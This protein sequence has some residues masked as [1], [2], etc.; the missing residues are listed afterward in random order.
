MK[1]LLLMIFVPVAA[2]LF[3][4]PW[5]FGAQLEKRLPAVIAQGAR[6]A[7]RYGL[8]LQLR[9]YRRGY[10]TST[11]QM[12]L[13]Y[14]PPGE[15][16][17][18]YQGVMTLD[19]RHAP[20]LA[21]G[22]D[23]MT[24]HLFSDNDAQGVL[25]QAL[26]PDFLAAS[27]SVGL[28]GHLRIEGRLLETRTNLFPHPNRPQHLAFHGARFQ[29]DSTLT[30]YP[31]RG[32]GFVELD[33]VTFTDDEQRWHLMPLRIGFAGED[34][35][36]AQAQLPELVLQ[37]SLHALS[38]REHIRISGFRAQMQQGLSADG[39]PYPHSLQYHIADFNWAR[40]QYGETH[41]QHLRDLNLHATL[42]Q[43]DSQAPNA[44]LHVSGQALQ[45][46]LPGGW[47]DIA[48]ETF[49]S[50]LEWQPFRIEDASALLDA[51]RHP[52]PAAQYVP[53]PEA[54]RHVQLPPGAG[55][56]LHYLAGHMARDTVR[57]RWHMRLSRRDEV[58]LSAEGHLH[59]HI[60]GENSTDVLQTLADAWGHNARLPALL[61]GSRLHIFAN[62]PFV[63]KSGLGIAL[64]FSG[65]KAY[66]D[67]EGQF[68]LDALVDTGGI[69]VN[70]DLLPLAP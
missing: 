37:H 8:A 15:Q 40:E 4:L 63:Q 46:D 35:Y 9:N 3:G 1:K 32:K 43:S 14:Q 42:R 49:E 41:T 65:H 19:I 61:Q 22:F 53:L 70:G 51:L 6:E 52:L 69:T 20:L 24:A 33:G 10:F 68:K 11:A 56:V 39:K 36:E 25:A 23:F 50:T 18:L 57:A 21:S 58:L 17:P 38:A 13:V 62:Q 55:H 27:A 7:E 12:L 54:W 16:V 28:N 30:G 29:I 67:G 2:G 5:F 59:E 26:P 44:T 48:P 47:Q 66:L 64:L 34:T 60:R 31:E 45:L